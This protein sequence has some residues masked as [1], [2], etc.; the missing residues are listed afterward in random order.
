MS[1]TFNTMIEEKLFSSYQV[2]NCFTERLNTNV[3]LRYS[4]HL[5]IVFNANTFE[6]MHF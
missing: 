5:I 4:S 3:A 1:H 6:K 2:L